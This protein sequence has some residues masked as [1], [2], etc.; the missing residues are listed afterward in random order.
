[1]K[2]PFLFESILKE[3]SR[4]DEYKQK[5]SECYNTTK[6]VAEEVNKRKNKYNKLVEIDSKIQTKKSIFN[7]SLPSMEFQNIL[8]AKK[9]TFKSHKMSVNEICIV[10]NQSVQDSGHQC[11]VCGFWAHKACSPLSSITTFFKK[12]ILEFLIFFS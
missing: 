3:C 12:K 1:M 8:N 11:S 4:D 2:I 9:H 5:I 7:D 6:K 10:C